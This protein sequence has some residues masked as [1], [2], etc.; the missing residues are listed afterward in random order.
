MQAKEV[1]VDLTREEARTGLHLSS[2]IKSILVG[3]DP[4][5][6]G[7]GPTSDS[8]TK[9]EL[10]FMWEDLL[11]RRRTG[12]CVILQAGIEKD[13]IRM[14]PDGFD[15]CE[16]KVLESKAT[17]MSARDPITAPKFRHWIW[18]VMAYCHAMDTQLA[19]LEVLFVNGT[20]S[21]DRGPMFKCWNLEF[22]IDEL[23]E[24][25]SMIINQKR[26]LQQTRRRRG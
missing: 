21:N 9:F 23:K 19:M 2:I 8:Y 13:G 4:K 12:Q 3:L 22:T 14:T 25:W 7:A 11:A 17:W 16:W 5:R 20:Y 24:N 1:R 15:I 26:H 6:F 18:Q 10:G